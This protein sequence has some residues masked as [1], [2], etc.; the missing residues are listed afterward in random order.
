MTKPNWSELVHGVAVPARPA[1]IWTKVYD[2][3][4]GPRRLRFRATGQWK[5]AASKQCGPDGDLS[6]GTAGLLQSCPVGS[7]VAK[8]GGGTAD[9]AA[10]TA[11]AGMPT[12]AFIFPVGSFC[13]IDLPSG[14]SGALFLTMNDSTASDDKKGFSVH[15]DVNVD[16]IIVDIDE[17]WS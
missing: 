7:L 11:V 15:E 8:I 9:T 5:F 4:S 12:P 16:P 3:V 14:L 17:S 1:G 13:T 10:L 2:Y 6:A